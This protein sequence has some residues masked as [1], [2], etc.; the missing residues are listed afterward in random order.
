MNLIKIEPLENGAHDNQLLAFDIEIP[1]G[2]AVIP[3]GMELPDSFPFVDLTV[4]KVDEVPTVTAMTAR[5]VPKTDTPEREP[6][7]AEKVTT[8]Q[9]EN[10]MLKQCLLEMS[11]NVY[12]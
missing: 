6:T 1:D 12:A 10:K 11:E 3:E 8:L 2:W 9:E 7:L 4:E 5:E